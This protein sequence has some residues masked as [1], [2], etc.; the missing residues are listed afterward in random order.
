MITTID[1]I[2][3]GQGW[4]VALEQ[5]PPEIHPLTSP[6]SCFVTRRPIEAWLTKSNEYGEYIKEEMIHPRH[7][8]SI[9][10]DNGNVIDYHEGIVTM[11]QILEDR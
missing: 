11:K 5:E 2:E 7:Y 1:G 9:L 6:E 3:L 10:M 8:V 4:G